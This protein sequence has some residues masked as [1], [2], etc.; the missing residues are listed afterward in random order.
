[1]VIEGPRGCASG[2]YELANFGAVHFTGATADHNGQTGPISAFSPIAY[3]MISGSTVLA[4]PGLLGPTG[5]EFTD[6]W[7]AG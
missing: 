5:E 6:A 4:A 7:Y 1:V 3:Q 2:C